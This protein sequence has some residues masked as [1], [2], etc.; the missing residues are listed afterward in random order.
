MR[1]VT[2]YLFAALFTVGCSLQGDKAAATN[3]SGVSP[4]DNAIEVAGG[5]SQAAPEPTPAAT[6]DGPKTIREFFTVLPDKYFTLE[7]CDRESDKDC[8]I[9]RAEYLKTLTEVED[10]KNG[11]FKGGCDGA[12][13]CIEMTIFKRPD[14]RYLVAVATFAEMINNFNF[15]EHDDGKWTDVGARDVPEFSKSNWYEL[16]RVGTTMTVYEAKVIEKGDDFEITEKGK[17]LY[18][19]VWKDGKFTRK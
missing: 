11:Y 10:V 9:A 7:G 19:L 2:F 6:S 5:G 15:L 16:P 13:S 3:A 18:E 4:A 17:K 1:A 14:G 12:Q 8:A